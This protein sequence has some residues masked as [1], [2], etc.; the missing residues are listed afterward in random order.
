MSDEIKDCSIKN[1]PLMGCHLDQCC[2]NEYSIEPHGDGWALYKGR[3]PS[4]HGLN[5]AH[6]T[7]AEPETLDFI[8]KALNAKT[9]IH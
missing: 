1:H 9:V 6:I 5:L 7:E 8:V 3:C 4:R 2:L